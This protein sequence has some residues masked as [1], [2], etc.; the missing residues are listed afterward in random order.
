MGLFQK[1]FK[2]QPGG[3]IVGNILRGVGDKFTGGLV[4]KLIPAPKSDSQTALDKAVETINSGNKGINPLVP[5][6]AKPDTGKGKKWAYIVGGIAGFGALIW[7]IFRPR[8]KRYGR[9]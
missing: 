8:K 2:R 1:L 7:L 6:T 4:S 9:R 3:S 5:D